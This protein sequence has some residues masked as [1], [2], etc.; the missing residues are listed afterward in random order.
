MKEQ[1]LGL[2]GALDSKTAASVE[3]YGAKLLVPAMSSRWQFL[4]DNL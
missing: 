1:K 3:A 4:P 2:S